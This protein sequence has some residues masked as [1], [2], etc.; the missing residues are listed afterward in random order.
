MPNRGRFLGGVTAAA[1]A[2]PHARAAL[3]QG[4][5]REIN[6]GLISPT[7]SMWPTFV[8]QELDLY[9]RYNLDPKFIFVGSVAACAQQLIAGALDVGEISSTQIVEAVKAGGALRYFLE[10]VVNPPYAFLA[11][12]PYKRYA[13]LKG[14]M[15]M[16]GGPADITVIFTEKMLA[17]GG[18]KM[19]DVDFT[20]AGG[21]SERYAALKSGSIAA[22]I[23][24]PPFSFR[25][26]AEG[27][28]LL[29]RLKDVMPPF[30][31]VGWAATEKYM[32]GH[33]DLL[34]DF[35]K[36]Q[37]RATRWLNDPANK[38]KAIEIL[39]R[40]GNAAPDDAA[41]SY[42]EYMVN[43]KAFPNGGDTSPATFARVV[44]ALAQLKVLTPPLP[45]P[46]NYY[47]NKFVSQA[48]AQLAREPK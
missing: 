5:L 20:Y 22:A 46:S 41:K 15:L 23:L 25:A 10:E 9:K 39:I 31:F 7:A 18:L 3:A 33:N 12:K 48:H 11:Q 35:S 21:T 38:A 40:R 44:D 32:G 13:D 37:L 42:D 19:A 47:D 26:A 4:T 36:A 30:P 6:M 2:A 1:V 8:A 29:G 45:P 34:V 28:N 17:S 14:K 43:M 24:A 16:I 27:Y